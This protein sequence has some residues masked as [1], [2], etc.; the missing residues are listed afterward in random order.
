M[1]FRILVGLPSFNEVDTIARVTHDIDVALSTLPFPCDALLVN[2]DNSSTDGTTDAFLSVVT[3]RDKRIVTTPYAA[4]KGANW[5]AL[6]R[7]TLDWG[8][9]CALFVDTDLAGVPESWTHALIGAVQAGANFCFPLR[10]PT[11]NGSDLT[12][13]LAYPLLAGVF[14][15][16]L[17]E[18]LCGEIALSARAVRQALCP[19]WT[20]DELR[21]GVDF[22]VASIAATQ[23]WQAVILPVPRQNKL[24]SF[25]ADASGEYR[26]GAK[27]AEVSGAIRS[28]VSWRLRQP[29]P[30]TFEVN[31]ARAPVDPEH[32][33]P[34][35]DADITQLA[36]MTTRRLRAEA[37]S[38]ALAIFP[39][40]LAGRL[41]AHTNS[42]AVTRGLSWEL[43]R[44][45]LFAWIASH[46]N[47]EQGAIPDDLF[48]ILF[49]NR[50][51]G[52]H[53]EIV[54]MT[55]W[56]STV[57]E[58]ARDLFLHRHV[59]WTET[60]DRHSPSSSVVE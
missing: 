17:R 42:A 33:A 23:T 46:N 51:V 25:S 4:G 21:F 30:R 26:M 1:L 57:L 11:W 58:Q 53:T 13:Q 22:R 5:R 56:Y 59:L 10:P 7:I 18:P 45:C 55:D 49:L 50:V 3:Q 24:R 32:L 14:G 12:Y 60:S 41:Q 39:S 2:A 47:R 28:R 8:F 54:G 44:E 37:R 19:E 31:S 16:D 52:H 29:P 15:A 6:L 38:G 43:W 48:E 36:E 35:Y 40:Q 34:L 9:D 20:L 27:F